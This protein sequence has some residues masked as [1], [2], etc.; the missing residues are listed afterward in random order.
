[1]ASNI[2]R[3]EDERDI[4]R[5][6]QRDERRALPTY[7]PPMPEPEPMEAFGGSGDAPEG[8]IDEA[9]MRQHIVATLKSIY[10]PEIPLNI[11]DLGLI[12]DL[13]IGDD[14]TVDVKM[15]LTAPGCPVADYLVKEV[16]D[17]VG[18]VPG[19]R[20]SHVVLVWDPPWTKDRMSEEALLELGLL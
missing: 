19:V 18:G 8:T 14:A 16:A 1:M 13:D 5:E 11:Y 17:K 10:D 4:E 15:T 9:A 20:Q 3:D 6:G 12:Y 2:E 7:P